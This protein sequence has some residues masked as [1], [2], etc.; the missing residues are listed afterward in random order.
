MRSLPTDAAGAV[1][2]G[3]CAAEPPLHDGNA[4]LAALEATATRTLSRIATPPGY[5][6][7][8]DYP[9]FEAFDPGF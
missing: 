3:A 9:G 2:E 1:Q 6:L 5:N 8:G 4:T 7:G